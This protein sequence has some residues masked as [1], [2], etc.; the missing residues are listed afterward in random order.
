MLTNTQCKNGHERT[1]ENTFVRK[2]G[3]RECKVCRRN[4]DKKRYPNERDHR[5]QLASK[6]T[7]EEYRK[8][9]AKFRKWGRTR[10]RR[11]DVK[12]QRHAFYYRT[13]NSVWRRYSVLKSTARKLGRDFTLSQEEYG[14][15]VADNKC[16]YCSGCLPQ[17]GCGLDRQD[18][19]MGYVHGN[20]VP[21]CERCNEH[22]G[23]LEGVGF[24]YPRTVELLMELVKS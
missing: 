23:S 21:C 4:C 2:D 20:V 24:T 11:P 16:H 8:H 5:S 7:Q 22:K 1:E 3:R 6:R 12:V 15:L 9:P 13:R 14:L 10:D 18:N 17:V 19:R